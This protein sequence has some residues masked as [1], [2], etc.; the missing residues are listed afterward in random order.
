[1]EMNIII[2]VVV[3]LV[4]YLIY[5]FWF[6]KSNILLKH[7]SDNNTDIDMTTATDP[8]SYRYTYSLC[9]VREHNTKI[10]P[11]LN[12]NTAITTPLT[13]FKLYLDSITAK[14]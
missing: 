5:I 3:A 1:M 12:R 10:K 13:Q 11:I 8:S 14:K 9:G 4:I 7:D 6:Y 2:G